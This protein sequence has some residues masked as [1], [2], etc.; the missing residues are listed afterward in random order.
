MDFK[1]IPVPEHDPSVGRAV[2]ALQDAY[3]RGEVKS[4]LLVYASNVG[5]AS[6]IVGNAMTLPFV[7]LAA[8][9]LAGDLI[10]NLQDRIT[11]A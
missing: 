10:S 2:Q 1:N 3:E 8:E 9:A 5:L 6:A 7:A 4:L 11:D